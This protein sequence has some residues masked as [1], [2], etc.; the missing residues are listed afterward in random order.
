MF[1]FT[2]PKLRLFLVLVAF[3]ATPIFG[4]YVELPGYTK[5][6][7][8]LEARTP[9]PAPKKLG[10][11]NANSTETTSAS[12]TANSAPNN[13]INLAGVDAAALV[14]GAAIVF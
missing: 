8:G 2:I 14:V 7:G 9:T 4:D 12:R 5:S 3:L 11:S 10:S 13:V 1:S 6:F